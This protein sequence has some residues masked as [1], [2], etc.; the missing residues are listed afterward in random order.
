M[1]KFM[2]C[3]VILEHLWKPASKLA[4]DRIHAL[5]TS[6]AKVRSIA[7]K[8][9]GGMTLLRLDYK[10]FIYMVSLLGAFLL[11]WVISW[12]VCLAAILVS[13]P[14][15]TW[16]GIGDS[17]QQLAR[18]AACQQLVHELGNRSSSSSHVLGWLQTQMAYWLQY[19]K[20][21]WARTTWLSSSWTPD[22]Q[23]L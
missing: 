19:H 15:A 7:Y 9:N 16:Q 4:F 13:N 1:G 23:K 3:F 14:V 18:T 12:I 2:G 6:R 8:R 5:C 20:R 17:S 21:P 22:P 10:K 11:F